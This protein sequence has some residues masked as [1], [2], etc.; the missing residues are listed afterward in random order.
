MSTANHPKAKPKASS[1]KESVSEQ[2]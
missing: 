1:H 2:S